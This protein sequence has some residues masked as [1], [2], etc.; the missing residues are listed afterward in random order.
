MAFTR[1]TKFLPF[2]LFLFMI[3]IHPAAA[4]FMGQPGFT[5]ALFQSDPLPV[6]ETIT[7]DNGLFQFEGLAA[8]DYRMNVSDGVGSTNFDSPLAVPLDADPA[9]LA[10]QVSVDPEKDVGFQVTADVFSEDELNAVVIDDVAI[11]PKKWNKSY[12]RSRGKVKVKIWGTDLETIQ[13][14]TMVTTTGS[15]HSV[16]IRLEEDE[17]DGLIAKAFFPKAEAFMDLIPADVVRGQVIPVD[18]IVELPASTVPF[19]EKVKILGRKN[20]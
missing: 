15:V 8:G 6:A 20:K 12:K 9:V 14:V 5:V 3:S 1:A 4:S 19:N 13:R 2:L 18:V 10:G 11:R 17:E 16:D 7:D